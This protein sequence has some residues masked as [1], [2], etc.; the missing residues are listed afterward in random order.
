MPSSRLDKFNEGYRESDR[1]ADRRTRRSHKPRFGL[2]MRLFQFCVSR[3]L[4]P[5]APDSVSDDDVLF[6]NDQ[7]RLN[8]S[9]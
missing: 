1:R 4:N 5:A 2:K 3:D 7:Q 9:D 8:T 6:I